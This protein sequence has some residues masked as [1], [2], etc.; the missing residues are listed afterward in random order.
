MMA[1]ESNTTDTKPPAW[2]A[3][4]SIALGVAGLI[5]AE[6]LPTGVLTPMARDLG[7][8]E[9]MTGQSV[10]ATSVAAVITSLTLPYFSRRMNRRTVML[11]LSFL[12]ICSNL[13]AAFSPNFGMLLSGR[14]I[15]GIALGGF[16]SMAAA[17]AMRLVPQAD[18]PRAIA[19]IFGGCSLASVVA[20]PLGSFL[21]G[22]IGWRNVF[23]LSATLSIVAFLWQAF[24]LPSLKPVGETSMRTIFDVLKVR[25]FSFGMLAVATVFCGHF[26]LFTYLRPFLETTTG[27]G[28]NAVSVI[29]LT[30]G[31]ANFIGTSFAGLMIEKN[32]RRTL[33]LLPFV[34]FL[35]TA[36]LF[37][38]GHSALATPMLVFL[39]G[40]TFGPV[41]VAWS[42]WVVRKVPE[43]AE[44]GGGIYVASVQFAAAIG[45]MVG[46]LAFDAS[47]SN[48]VI[49]LSGISWLLSSLIV[50]SR[51]GPSKVPACEAV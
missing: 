44:T 18:G 3:V 43:Y 5:M 14:F 46:G 26:A 9:G 27:V 34:L 45:A 38:F 48:G 19:I 51:I 31:V 11:I 8:S 37:R 33:Y 24:T 17:I 39:W 29:L 21:G 28:V 7:I 23:L 2:N 47:G 1:I 6:F 32:M 41:P 40:V 42:A 4:F 12:L 30:F 20:A 49:M 16:W 10:T 22:I 35:V 50:A 36:G 15:L 13:V 25:H